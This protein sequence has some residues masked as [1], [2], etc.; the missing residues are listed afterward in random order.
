[1]DS[2]RDVR[3]QQVYDCV[4]RAGQAGATIQDVAKA[5][6]K[7]ADGE[8]MTVTPYL[9]GLLDQLVAEGH[10]RKEPS[11]IETGRGLRMGWRYWAIS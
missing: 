9:T 10:L 7:K 2:I 8:A 6:P 1:M 4:Y 11:M 5:M 3:R